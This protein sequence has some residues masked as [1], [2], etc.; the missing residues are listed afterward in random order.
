MMQ[1]DRQEE[2]LENELARRTLK[3]QMLKTAIFGI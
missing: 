2:E 3:I 1:Y